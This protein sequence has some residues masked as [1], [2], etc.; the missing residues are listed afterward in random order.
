MLGRPV[1]GAKA[2]QCRQLLP[3]G[4]PEPSTTHALT[5]FFYQSNMKS[6]SP[7]ISVL[8]AACVFSLSSCGR[9]NA[10]SE[11]SVSQSGVEIRDNVD[12]SVSEGDWASW[13]GLTGDGIATG[14]DPPIHWDDAT[15]VL[16]RTDVPGR[17]HGSPIVVGGSIYLATADD[18]AQEPVSYTH[19]TLPT[20]PYV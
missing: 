1:Q 17:G 2:T 7:F 3:L 6:T 12:H 15:N 16:W 11:V 13:R 9:K 20:T 5:P 19:L 10:V 4:I 8:L 14:Q 18:E